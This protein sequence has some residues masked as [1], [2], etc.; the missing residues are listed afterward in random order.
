MATYI[1]TSALLRLVEGHGDTTAVDRAMAAQPCCSTL[2]ELECW[3]AIHKRWHDGAF[4]VRMRDRLLDDAR[5]LLEAVDTL[6]LSEDVLAE[7]RV[8][9]RRY[10]LRALDA[11]H[12]A[13]ASMAERR[14]AGTAISLR[15]CTADRRQAAVARMH[16]GDDRVDLVPPWR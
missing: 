11:I 15:F 2:G 7:T 1:D 8:L 6:T 13:T 14:L 10:P 4:P 16:F 3:S 9:V 12:L 5:T